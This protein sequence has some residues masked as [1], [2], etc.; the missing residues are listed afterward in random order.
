MQCIAVLFQLL[1]ARNHHVHHRNLKPSRN[2][3]VQS[4]VCS[5]TGA[6]RREAALEAAAASAAGG[7]RG[8][9]TGACGTVV[10]TFADHPGKVDWPVHAVMVTCLTGQACHAKSALFTCRSPETTKLP[11]RKPFQT[12]LPG[13]VIC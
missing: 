11:F 9:T 2:H 12:C 13:T 6:G 4:Y 7:P 10:M 5:K 1:C 8:P 3:H